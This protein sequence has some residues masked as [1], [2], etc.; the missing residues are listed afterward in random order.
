MRRLI[1]QYTLSDKYHVQIAGTE[2]ADEIAVVFAGGWEIVGRNDLRFQRGALEG[3]GIDW[4]WRRG[5]DWYINFDVLK[6]RFDAF[7]DIDWLKGIAPV[8][9][10]LEEYPDGFS[11]RSRTLLEFKVYREEFVVDRKRKIFLSHKGADKP[12]VREFF[13]VLR[14]IGFDPWLDED[15]MVA[16]TPLERGILEGFEQSC[17]AVFFVTPNFRD[18]NYL[19]TEVNYALA[20]KRKKVDR[21]AIITIVF[22]EKGQKG[23]VPALLEQYVWKEPTTHLEALDEIL[24]SLPIE[25]GEPRWKAHISP[26]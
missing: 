14:T 26:A 20:Q 3:N 5:R 1:F 23:K 10:D 12:T 22:T 2:S 7:R 9:P 19:A 21:F 18:E 4:I 17:A 13:R 16:G 6:E 25:P 8:Q 11:G 15:A 24:R